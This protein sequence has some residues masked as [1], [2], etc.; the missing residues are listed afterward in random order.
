[1]SRCCSLMWLLFLLC[2]AAAAADDDEVKL[3]EAEDEDKV[4]W[5]MVGFLANAVAAVSDAK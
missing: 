4:E 3:D 5:K 2:L 1:M